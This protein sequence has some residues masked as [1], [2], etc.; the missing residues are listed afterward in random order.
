[1]FNNYKNLLKLIDLKNNNNKMKNENE[2]ENNST[3]L[4][5]SHN[6]FIIIEKS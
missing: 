1:M 2:N 5:F 3:D 4:E 6:K